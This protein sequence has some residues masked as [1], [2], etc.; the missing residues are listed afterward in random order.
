MK[1]NMKISKGVIICFLMILI[2][3]CSSSVLVDEWKDP[4]YKEAPLGKIFVIVMRKDAVK[5]RIWED[6]F[7]NELTKYGIKATQSYQLFPIALPDT[8][9]IIQTIQAKGYDG[10]LVARHLSSETKT[11]YV[12]SYITQEPVQRYNT[13]RKKYDSYFLEVNHPGYIDS[14]VVYRRA[15]DV[16]VVRNE[17]RMIWSATSNSPESNS[18]QEVQN[19]I[20]DLVIPELVR[21]AIIKK[22]K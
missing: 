11:N 7:V 17:E 9:Q 12:P 15:I 5:R 13:F 18:V 19:D 6:A 10:I 2:E 16:W 1:L 22:E 8:D 20:A 4:S 14:Q 3:S 21:N